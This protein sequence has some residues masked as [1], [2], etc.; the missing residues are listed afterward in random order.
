MVENDPNLIASSDNR[1]VIWSLR[2][3]VVNDIIMFLLSYCICWI[4]QTILTYI[5][6]YYIINIVI[7]TLVIYV[8]YVTE[9]ISDDVA[10]NMEGKVGKRTQPREKSNEKFR[11]QLP[12]GVSNPAFWASTKIHQID[13]NILYV[14]TWTISCSIHLWRT[15]SSF[16]SFSGLIMCS[17]QTYW[18]LACS[19]YITGLSICTFLNNRLNDHI[20]MHTLR[21]LPILQALILIILKL[22]C[23][24]L[25][26]SLKLWCPCHTVTYLLP[27]RPQ[28]SQF[29]VFTYG[30]PFHHCDW[31]SIYLILCYL[32]LWSPV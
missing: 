18:I 13:I 23:I 25:L 30:H 19:C 15:N 11:V 9:K 31:F 27:Y 7:D 24:K 29:A 10:I 3:L 1:T 6:G 8:A 14:K 26:W 28:V 4:A 16:F 5:A 20:L 22:L 17:G 2:P 21:L 12:Q 32:L